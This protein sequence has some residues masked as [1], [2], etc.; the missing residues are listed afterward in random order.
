[1]STGIPF[2]SKHP[3]SLLSERRRLR[4]ASSRRRVTGRPSVT[5]C[6]RSA[7]KPNL[8]AS[9]RDRTPTPSAAS[10][11]FTG[12]SGR[13]G[14]DRRSGLDMPAS[15]SPAAGARSTRSDGY[16]RARMTEPGPAVQPGRR[17][18]APTRGDDRT[19]STLDQQ[20]VRRRMT[21]PRQTLPEEAK[22]AQP[23]KS[24]H[25]MHEVSSLWFGQREIFEPTAQIY[26]D[27]GISASR[28]AQ[29][30]TPVADSHGSN[31][32][33]KVSVRSLLRHDRNA[34]RVGRFAS[35]LHV[36]RTAGV[37]FLGCPRAAK[38]R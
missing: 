26:E 29:Q 35:G 2:R 11:L 15:G 32:A 19:G 8:R 3:K 36:S 30:R 10:G 1:M 9:V 37:D 34:S 16:E 17:V 4:G 12:S 14:R 7:L 25:T 22:M 31:D 13:G 28:S 27:K 18:W 20:A 5:K 33:A 38:P 24:E 6:A 21:T 23:G